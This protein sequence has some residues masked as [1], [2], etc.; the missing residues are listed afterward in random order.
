MDKCYRDCHNKYFHTIKSECKYDFKLTNII[1]NEKFNL[2]ISDESMI[3]YNLI[4]KLTV[5]RQKGSLYNQI[6]T[7]TIKFYSH[8]RQINISYYL[9]SQIPMCHRHFFRVISQ[10][11]DY[12][13]NFCKDRNNLF[14]LHVVNGCWKVAQ[15]FLLEGMFILKNFLRIF[16]VNFTRVLDDDFHDFVVIAIFISPSKISSMYCATSFLSLWFSI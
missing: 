9:K 2:T 11:R 4:K 8:L 13:E 6:N 3:L 7:L 1:S 15:N 5:A 14:I 12:V 16:F 10:I